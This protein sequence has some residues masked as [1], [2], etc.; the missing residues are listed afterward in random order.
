MSAI[1]KECSPIDGGVNEVVRCLR[2]RRREIEHAIFTHV[3]ETVPS[4][5]AES[6]AEYVA[7]L[8]AAVVASLEYVLTGIE[9][10]WEQ[11]LPE[12]AISQA[13]RAARGGVSLDAVLRRYM[14]GQTLLWEYILQEADR[15]ARIGYGDG[16]REI[17]R[18]QALL[19]DRLMTDVA[20]EYARER[21]RVEHSHERRLLE[22][23][24]ELLGGEDG[25]VAAASADVLERE[26]GYGLD[27]EHLGVIA[28]GPDA[29]QALQELA[30][31]L[32]R[33][34]LSVPNGEETV[35]GWLGGR[36]GL[37][38]NQLQRALSE[39]ASSGQAR[40]G[41]VPKG[42][43]P[44]QVM[45]AVGEPA[46]GLAGWRLTHQQAQAALV[47]ALRRPQRLTRYVDV[48]LLASA[49]KDQALVRALIDTY[50]APLENGRNGAST[51]LLQTLRAYLAA[52][53]NSS[54]AAVV[55]HVARSTVEKRMRAIEEKIGQ[56]LNPCPVQLEVA[57][58]LHDLGIPPMG[59]ESSGE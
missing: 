59:A 5:A 12:E 2:E 9:R 20:K 58:E 39:R 42:S 46:R 49:L 53:R 38:M 51:E 7:G 16:A 17:V 28:R 37:V 54:S 56:T 50:I 44:G 52:G 15:V 40:D 47:V 14:A 29:Q 33:R 3:C 23:V 30:G 10:G 32:D 41:Q 35:W 19:V 55:L 22:S 48:A 21:E 24:R 11:P 4:P 43:A 25:G 36:R 8:R 1:A 13:R 34:L 27:A 31:G 26:F 6:D 57:L 18:V 45:F